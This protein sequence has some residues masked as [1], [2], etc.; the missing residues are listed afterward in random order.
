MPGIQDANTYFSKTLRN[1]TWVSHDESKRTIAIEEA[2]SMIARLPLSD[3]VTTE[4][5]DSAI[6][7]QAYCLLNDSSSN[8]RVN[9]I[10]QGVTSRSINGGGGASEAYRTDLSGIV[11]F[12]N[13]IQIC[14]RA[15]SFI[16][17]YI[18]TKPKARSGSIRLCD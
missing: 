5:K 10:M 8:E 3:S 6:Y 12:Y 18:N 11:G 17:D 16:A 7:E 15:Y 1:D 14:P 13:G 2:G 9:A 4:A